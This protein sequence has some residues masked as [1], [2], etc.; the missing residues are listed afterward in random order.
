MGH[1]SIAITKLQLPKSPA[2][3]LLRSSSKVFKQPIVPS[4]LVIGAAAAIAYIDEQNQQSIRDKQTNSML[5]RQ[6]EGER[7]DF[8]DSDYATIMLQSK[9]ILK[10]IPRLLS[11]ALESASSITQCEQQPQN[12]VNN[13]DEADDDNHHYNYLPI[14]IDGSEYCDDEEEARNFRQTLRYHKSIAHVYKKEWDWKANDAKSSHIPTTSWPLNV[15]DEKEIR[16]LIFDLQFCH[17][18]RRSSP[19]KKKESADG[20]DT[21][22]AKLEEDNHVDYCQDLQFRIASHLLSQ[23]EEQTQ[24]KGL[25]LNMELVEHH[26]HPDAMCSYATCLNDGRAGLL[27]PNPGR[28]TNW[29]KIASDQYHHV[30]SMY[31]L[32]VAYY[33]GEGVAED[34]GIAVK[35]FGR[36]AECGHVGAA[37]MLGDC[38]LDGVGVRRD[39]GEALEWLVTAAELGHRGARSRVLAVL[40]KKEGDNYG[41]FT[42]SSRQSLKETDDDNDDEGTSEVKMRAILEPQYSKQNVLLERRFTIGGGARNPAVLARR[43]TIVQESRAEE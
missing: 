3:A 34:E 38:L 23:I 9:T 4:F 29:W 2:L 10:T 37:Y 26:R 21:I 30:Q 20:A 41:E 8:K 7:H 17:G 43:R 5:Q 1:T 18:T 24:Q 36:A 14:D 32:G 42:D 13:D 19:Q 40:E 25:K 15:P 28:A 33:T 16:S 12:T 6:R 27:E 22:E 35:Y 31:E 11:C 39:R